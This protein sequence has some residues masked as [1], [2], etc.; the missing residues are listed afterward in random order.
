MPGR[1]CLELARELLA[2]GTLPPH[3][4]AVVIHVY[5]ALFL[6]CRDAMSRWR[7]PPLARLNVHAQVRLR[8]TRSTSPDL[9]NI[10]NELEFLV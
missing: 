10:G 5:Y 7:L 3:W 6:E 9:C 1:E 2:L 8:E 4:R